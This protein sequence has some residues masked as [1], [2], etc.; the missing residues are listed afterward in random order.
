MII[1]LGMAFT[2]GAWIM[3]STYTS[4]ESNLDIRAQDERLHLEQLL[5]DGTDCAGTMAQI[6]LTDPQSVIDKC[7]TSFADQTTGVTTPTFVPLINAN[8]D[9]VTD[10][11]DS[12]PGKNYGKSGNWSFRAGCWRSGT[13]TCLLVHSAKPWEGSTDPQNQFQPRALLSLQ[14]SWKKLPNSP[15]SNCCWG[16]PSCEL[17]VNPDPVARDTTVTFTLVA[18]NVTSATMSTSDARIPAGT[19]FPLSPGFMTTT[20]TISGAKS[21]TAVVRGPGGTST[22]TVNYLVVE[23]PICDLSITSPVAS[24]GVHQVTSGQP[25]TLSLTWTNSASVEST[26]TQAEIIAYNMPPAPEVQLPLSIPF[27]VPTAVSPT[28][29]MN[30]VPPVG[31]TDQGIAGF[32]GRY[33][34]TLRNASGSYYCEIPDPVAVCP[35]DASVGFYENLSPPVNCTTCDHSD[36]SN[37]GAPYTVMTHGFSVASNSTQFPNLQTVYQ[38]YSASRADVWTAATNLGSVLEGYNVPATPLFYAYNNANEAPGLIPIATMTKIHPAQAQ[39]EFVFPADSRYAANLAAYQTQGYTQ[40]ALPEFYACPVPGNYT[41]VAQGP[42]AGPG[43]GVPGPGP[44]GPGPSPGA[45]PGPGPGPAAPVPLDCTWVTECENPLVAPQTVSNE[46]Q[47][48]AM[49]PGGKYILTQNIALSATPLSI[50]IGRSKFFLDGAGYTVTGLRS[51]QGL[52]LP[53]MT[54]HAGHDPDTISAYVSGIAQ[55]CIKNI[56]FENAVISTTNNLAGVLAPH[57]DPQGI[58]NVAIRNSTVN[59]RSRVGGAVG[60]AKPSC[61]STAKPTVNLFNVTA[62]GTGNFVGGA[63]GFAHVVFNGGGFIGTNVNVRGVNYLG[64]I[65]GQISYGGGN[66][67]SV[68]LNNATVDGGNWI[69]GVVGYLT[70]SNANIR[71]V[72]ITGSTVRGA[73]SYT[74]GVVGHIEG[75]GVYVQDANLTSMTVEGATNIG[76]IVGY[77]QG[78]GTTLNNTDY[79]GSIDGPTAQCIGQ[80]AGV[81][82]ATIPGSTFTGTVNG[83][84]ATCNTA[85]V[86]CSVPE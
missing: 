48:R 19:P 65:V 80:L 14:E 31:R 70:G 77:I 37:P 72:T 24:G 22:C 78:A 53:E 35:L 27:P 81:G 12:T 25:V 74:G 10:S 33:V 66:V 9:L 82:S 4:V 84:A 67:R 36:Y 62:Q 45:S 85:Q 59:G 63:F 30:I 52:I 34:A 69:G 57:M 86:C 46:A 76:G 71:N 56:T 8:G 58:Y 38:Q 11:Y 20:H 55:A 1:L 7:T 40:S 3:I 32:R 29:S 43:P 39:D 2:I 5:M 16:P 13:N 68:S 6:N 73:G 79:S 54:Y 17:M 50:D 21:A 60:Q 64:G 51:E 41:P 26:P 18:S 75:A 61:A 23:P 42:G 28:Q 15:W 44:A 49:V 47:F 83:P